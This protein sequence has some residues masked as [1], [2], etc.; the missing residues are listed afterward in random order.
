MGNRILTC[1]D[2]ETVPERDLMPADWD[3]GKFPPLPFHRIVTIS[4]LEAEIKK[5]GSDRTEWFDVKSITSAGRT[6]CDEFTMV[7]AFWNRFDRVRPRLVTWNGRGFDCALLT[8]KAMVHGIQTP[9]WVEDRDRGRGY[10]HRYSSD[11]HCDLADVMSNFGGRMMALDDV[12]KAMGLPGKFGGHGSDVDAL[13]AAGRHSENADYCET[14]VMNLFGLFVR[15]SYQTCRT[16]AEGH[17]RSMQS[18][19][20]LCN[21]QRHARPHLGEFVDRWAASRRPSP[22]MLDL[23]S[24]HSDASEDVPEPEAAPAP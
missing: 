12:C 13:H 2:V 9:A 6:A 19:I 20:D 10:G 7:E 5:S 4:L 15:H 16:N 17:N 14:D 21:E 24:P 8:L 11:H 23:G 22:H 18:L 3:P 1:L